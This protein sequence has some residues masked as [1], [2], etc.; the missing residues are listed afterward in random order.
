M[1]ALSAAS[2]LSA[3]A[4]RI[5]YRAVVKGYW[6]HTAWCITFLFMHLALWRGIW[7][8]TGD[9]G[10]LTIFEMLPYFQWVVFWY[11]ASRL[12][13]PDVGATN[14]VDLEAYFFQ[15][16]TPFLICVWL[17]YTLNIVLLL[18]RGDN[19]LDLT[20]A[21]WGTVVVMIGSGLVGVFTT[22]RRVHAG[23]VCVSLLAIL[24]QE[25]LQ[26]AIA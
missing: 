22:D 19:S 16:K 26:G 2:T 17:P 15:I 12:L 4:H 18:L 7:L 25:E 21:M 23:I 14:E 24:V 9:W 20:P 13:A 8:T 10:E 3:L 6:V 1:L 5:K 11:L